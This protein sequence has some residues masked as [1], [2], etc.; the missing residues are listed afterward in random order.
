MTR[1]TQISRR[2]VQ[3]ISS[4]ADRLYSMVEGS[5]DFSRMQNG[6]KLDLQLLDLVAEV[7]DA[8]I[9]WSAAW[10]WRAC[11]LRMTNPKSRCR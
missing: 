3:V 9:M 5:L 7:S 8:A 2:G 1:P 10:S 4:E 11:I 6:L